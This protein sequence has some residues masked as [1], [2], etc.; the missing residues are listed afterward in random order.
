MAPDSRWDRIP[1]ESNILLGFCVLFVLILAPVLL[2]G[3]LCG[4][5]PAWHTNETVH[6]KILAI[7]D[8]HGQ[9]PA[10]QTLN[11][12]HAGSIPVLASYLKSSMASGKADG[13]IIAL[14]GDV[15]GASPPE[16]GLL[17]DEPTLLFFNGY[18]NP[19]CAIGSNSPNTSCNMV[20]TPGNH[21]FD[22]GIPE[23]MRKINGGNGATNITHLVDPYP[24]TRIDY[25]CAN[26]VWETNNT[27]VLPP[28]TLRNVGGVPIAFIGVDTMN[29]PVLEGAAQVKGVTFLDEADSINR[30]IPEIRKQGVHAIVVLLHEGGNQT[31]YDGP[32]RANGT[33]TGRVTDIIPRLDSDVDVVLSAHTHEFTNTYLPNAGKKPVLVTQAYMYSMGYADIDLTIDK[34]SGDIIAKSAQ[35]IP[36][37]ADQPPGTSPDPAATAFLAMDENALSSIENQLIGVSAMNITRTQNS[38]GEETLGDMVVD[39]QRAAMKTDVGFGTAGSIRADLAVGN[40]TWGNLYAVQ[41]F[42]DTVQ[43]MTLSGAQIQ[44]AL[45][46]QWQEPLPPH[47]LLVSGLNYTWDASKPAGSKVTSVTI[48]GVLLNQKTMYT[49][50]MVTY[51]A[52]GGDRYTTFKEEK[53]IKNGPLDIDALVAYVESLP[54]PVNMTADGRVQRIN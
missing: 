36:T 31:P 33:V 39:G 9:L 23:L 34:S 5:V 47:N 15:F 3:Y 24:G 13:I 38:A 51:L 35:I 37:Y 20:A 50:S 44:E 22:K 30:Y 2:S 11:N 12:R 14:P 4:S 32:T 17:L 54:Q 6:V 19:Y 29:T 42:G 27:P 40:I 43:S 46:Q 8:F 25:V 41:P 16:S 49:V 52:G 1:I 10:G 7:N 48:H 26:V 18:A 21:E 53:N 28:Y 45:E